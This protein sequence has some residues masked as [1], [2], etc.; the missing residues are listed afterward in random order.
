MQGSLDAYEY[1]GNIGLLINTYKHVWLIY[2]CGHCQN[3]RSLH[4]QGANSTYTYTDSEM[5]VSY[6][7]LCMQCHGVTGIGEKSYIIII[8]LILLT[9]MADSYCWH[10]ISFVKNGRFVPMHALIPSSDMYNNIIV[11]SDCIPVVVM[12]ILCPPVILYPLWY[13]VI[14]CNINC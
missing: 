14:N 1:T 4:L 5:Y 13:K 2:T 9:K 6:Y 11:R 12:S 8:L 3:T 10:K 7:R